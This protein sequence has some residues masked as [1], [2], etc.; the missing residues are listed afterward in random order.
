MRGGDPVLNI[1]L[2][3]ISMVLCAVGLLQ[4]IIGG[5]RWKQPIFSYVLFYLVLFLYAGVV[6]AGVI[7]EGQPGNT[8][9]FLLNASGFIKAICAYALSYIVVRGLLVR[10][11]PRKEKISLY[12]TAIG[13]LITQGVLF[14]V[15]H[16][17][18]FVSYVDSTNHTHFSRRFYI[19]LAIW[20]LWLVFSVYLLA[21]YGKK[22]K[23][24]NFIIFLVLTLV[25]VTGIILQI[26][27]KGIYFAPLAAAV[28][29]VSISI[30]FIIDRAQEQFEAEREIEKLKTDIM[31][32]QIQPHFLY[33]SLT[34]I[35]H[36][37][38]VDP[39]GA[40]KAVTEFAYFL[41]GNMDSL[42]A[43]KLI[44]FTD[45]LNH[46]RAYFSMEKLRFGDDLTIEE[47]IACTAFRIP[48]LTL[49][50]IVENAVRHG[51]REA[52]NG[53]GKVTI[54]TQEYPDR[55]EITVT[56]DGNGFDTQILEGDDHDHL[57]IRNVRYRLEH[58]TK[59]SLMIEST[60]G[61]GTK[62]VIALP[63]QI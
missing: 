34:T 7:I 20:L 21:R 61:K 25:A 12:R 57:G 2:Q 41:R 59:G 48:A 38:R 10:I 19:L 11:D 30:G 16:F 8:V 3:I 24:R 39:E 49:Q 29:A 18:G 53:K 33:N 44:D 36:L 50:P 31:L 42:T 27:F 37:C 14:A 51:I 52:E 54:S 6:L 62:A 47:Q 40:E 13:L 28:G 5:K 9:H 63:K 55:Y 46:T 60:V 15:V 35:K 26:I 1:V 45:E 23:R 4:I 56:D 43:D 32:S 58:M 17:S 22:L